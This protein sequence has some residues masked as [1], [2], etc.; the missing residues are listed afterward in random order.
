LIRPGLDGTVHVFNS[1]WRWGASERFGLGPLFK[2][3]LGQCSELIEMSV[4]QA[5]SDLGTGFKQ[6]TLV[7]KPV[8][9]NIGMVG[10]NA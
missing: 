1:E 5:Q 6:L 8:C 3:Q 7:W 10:K 2:G 9:C 4:P